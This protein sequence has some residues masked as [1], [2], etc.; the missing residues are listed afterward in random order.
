ME[1]RIYLKVPM[2]LALAISKASKATRDALAFGIGMALTYFSIEFGRHL[3]IEWLKRRRER[4]RIARKPQKF[5]GKVLSRKGLSRTV[6]RRKIQSRKNWKMHKYGKAS[7]W[8]INLIGLSK[9]AQKCPF[10]KIT[11]TPR[12]LIH[13]AFL[14]LS[15]SVLVMGKSQRVEKRTEK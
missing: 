6:L 2:I 8:I 9:E 3:R 1:D 10:R 4:E 13:C 14:G 7:Q 12:L 11:S 15:A 5:K